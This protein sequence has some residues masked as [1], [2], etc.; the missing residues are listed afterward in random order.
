MTCYKSNSDRPRCLNSTPSTISFPADLSVKESNWRTIH[1]TPAYQSLRRP[2]HKSGEDLPSTHPWG[3]RAR[4]INSAHALHWWNQSPC[5][6]AYPIDDASVPTTPPRSSCPARGKVKQISLPQGRFHH[7]NLRGGRSH[8]RLSL[9]ALLYTEA[10]KTL[11][12]VVFS[13]YAYRS[14]YT[15]L[16]ASRQVN[17]S[18]SNT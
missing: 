7:L 15:A 1:N 8:P 16:T 12:G 13:H 3:R 14:M 2:R 4:Y 9:T 5:G 17:V 18:A 6:A 11:Y 10:P